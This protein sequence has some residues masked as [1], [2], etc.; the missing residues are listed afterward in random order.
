[1]RPERLIILLPLLPLL[2][3]SSAADNNQ[4]IVWHRTGSW[5]KGT[6]TLSDFA[7]MTERELL[8]W[9]PAAPNSEIVLLL[10]GRYL[11]KQCAGVASCSITGGSFSGPNSERRS[12]VLTNFDAAILSLSA[13]PQ[14]QY[15][16]SRAVVWR[17]AVVSLDV[18]RKA[19]LAD[20]FASARPREIAVKLCRITENKC[21]GGLRV[22]WDG[23]VAAFLL[24][25]GFEDSTYRLVAENGSN[26]AWVRF[27]DPA[28]LAHVRESY[29][30]AVEVIRS[31]N[32][33]VSMQ[34]TP[35]L[36]RLERLMLVEVGHE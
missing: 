15:P 26:E 11:R 13:K 1:M 19:D 27:V 14:M 24:P 33:P 2:P 10:N 3:Q 6:E 25:L 5:R 30:A 16:M 12:T 29:K 35:P 31:W 8:Q 4:G 34:D 23:K 36:D 18:Q 20:V 21:V 28:R 17:D 9:V 22:N 32:W 7:R